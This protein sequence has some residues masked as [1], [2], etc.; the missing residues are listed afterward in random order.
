MPPMFQSIFDEPYYTEDGEHADLVAPD[1]AR[2][3]VEPTPEETCDVAFGTEP[4]GIG[5][6]YCGEMCWKR[7]RKPKKVEPET[8]QEVV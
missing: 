5:W 3:S 7:G 4:P 1:D 6:V 2:M 8:K